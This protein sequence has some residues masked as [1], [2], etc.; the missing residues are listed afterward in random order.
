MIYMGGSVCAGDVHLLPPLYSALF[1][2]AA[3]RCLGNAGIFAPFSCTCLL[4][5]RENP[6]IIIISK[7]EIHKDIY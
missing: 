5:E 4:T 7:R 1:R 2:G 3:A 6:S